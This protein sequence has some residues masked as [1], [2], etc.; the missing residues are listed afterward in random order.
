MVFLGFGISIHVNVYFIGLAE[1]VFKLSQRVFDLENKCEFLFTLVQERSPMPVKTSVTPCSTKSKSLSNV[2]LFME[3]EAEIQVMN[4]NPV[5]PCQPQP[6]TETASNTIPSV[7]SDL[8][9]P[10]TV[11]N[12]YPKLMSLSNIGRLSVR[13]ACEAYF[14]KD[15]LK[16]CTVVGN[17]DKPALP[18]DRVQALK[19]KL[20]SL[21]PQFRT[22]PIEFEPYWSKCIGAINHCAAGMRSKEQAT[23][24]LS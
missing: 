15:L 6:E 2:Q 12:R 14:R 13:L 4:S 18:K 23:I 3:P 5:T 7:S 22:A 21:H 11:I 1:Q 9:P 17:I 10:D 19:S 8:L 16:K 20:M 24:T